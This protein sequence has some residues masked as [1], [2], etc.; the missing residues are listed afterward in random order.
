MALFLPVIQFEFGRRR[1]G[2]VVLAGLVTSAGVTGFVEYR[3][4]VK[5]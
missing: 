4:L 5:L 1:E 3:P 2:T